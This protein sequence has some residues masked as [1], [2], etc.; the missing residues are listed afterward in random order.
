MLIGFF[1]IFIILQL[2]YKLITPAEKYI[3]KLINYIDAAELA[4]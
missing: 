4:Y 1:L 3:L 2:I